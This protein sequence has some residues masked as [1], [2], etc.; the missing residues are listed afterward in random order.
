MT[1][2]THRK[3]IARLLLT[4]ALTT[5]IVAGWWLWPEAPQASIEDRARIW[6]ERSPLPEPVVAPSDARELATTHVLT[7]QDREVMTEL[8][9]RF[10][11]HIH[12]QHAQIKLIEQLLAYLQETYPDNWRDIAYQILGELFPEL[13]ESLLAKLDGLLALN[14]WLGE[15]RDKLRGMSQQDRR[16]ALWAARYA[17]FGEAANEI[18]AME[19]RNLQIRE[20]L[21]HVNQLD[22]QALGDKLDIYL[23]AIQSAYGDH[24]QDFMQSRQTELTSQFLAVE[25]VQDQLH[26]LP[27]EER[28]AALMDIRRALGMSEAALQRWAALDQARDRQW[29]S[30][31]QYMQKRAQVMQ[32][33]SGEERDEQLA[34]LRQEQFGDNA[35]TIRAEEEAGFYRYSNRRRYG[36]E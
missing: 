3:P 14:A 19:L 7:A 16:A 2:S 34:R 21:D 28:S 35:D 31:Q 25:A 8:Q 27:E 20:A 6:A 26:E 18:W 10:A 13:A 15:Y 33:H 29:A 22:G 5:T 24:A 1:E 30:G 9:A 11:P 23:G 17:T 12:V 4:L 32:S 36:R